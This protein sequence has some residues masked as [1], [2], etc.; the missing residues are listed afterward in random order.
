MADLFLGIDLGTSGARALVMDAGGETVAEARSPMADHGADLRDPGVW[1]A[2]VE[3]ALRGA[4]AQ[5]DAGRIAA[6]AV[7]GTSGTMLALDAEGRP[8]GKGVMYNDPCPDADLLAAIT[9]ASPPETAARGATSALARAVL[10]ARGGAFR[11]A[12][13]ADWIA[14]R[15]GGP[16]A[17]DANNALKTGYDP[18]AGDWPAWVR[19]MV[20]AGLLPPVEAPA[21]PLGRVGA[22]PFGLPPGC[23]IVAGTTDGCASFLATGASR[24]GDGVTAIGTTLTVKLLSDRP[25]FAP[26][27]G[28]Y[29]HLVLGLWLAGGASNAGGAVILQEF[30]GADI[31]AL[32]ARIDPADPT[33]LDYYPLPAPG[34]RF[35][36]ND[37]S[38]APR[39]GPRPA[40]D[41]RH[42]QAIFEGLA[43][44]EATAYRRL[45]ELGAPPLAALRSVGGAAASRALTA[46]RARRLG[47]PMPPPVSGEAARG[48]A[49]LARAGAAA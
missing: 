18:V 33:G 13:Q 15:L 11:V 46:I 16:W 27:Y 17:S 36:V 44:V 22:N 4:L 37:P 34:E 24:A 38:L 7:D 19:A 41:H 12:H 8:Q 40:E 48:A 39:L 47:V 14:M 30:P 45:A 23:A 5:V 20:P 42:L 31:D 10:L 6:L 9:A 28:I 1:W 26:D 21:T 35:P 2:A 49:I 43:S 25:V 29:S 3:T 32:S